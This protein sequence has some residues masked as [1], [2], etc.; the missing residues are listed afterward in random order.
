MAHWILNPMHSH[1]Q[2]CARA[3]VTPD[4]SRIGRR[5]PSVDTA[6]LSRIYRALPGDTLAFAHT[7]RQVCEGGLRWRCMYLPTLVWPMSMPSLSSSP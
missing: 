4:R 6:A 2:S 5:M 7:L 1:L 3:K